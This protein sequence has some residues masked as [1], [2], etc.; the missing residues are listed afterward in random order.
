M[1]AVGGPFR[2]HDVQI[3]AGSNSAI[4]VAGGRRITLKA[5]CAV[6][7]QWAHET[8]SQSYWAACA[9]AI[10]GGL[11]WGSSDW[12]TAPGLSTTER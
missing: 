10:V 1:V 12:L 5:T 8:M 6:R 11:R 9:C 7:P 4:G 3:S 2:P